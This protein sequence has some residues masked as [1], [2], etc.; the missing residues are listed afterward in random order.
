MSEAP[1]L[2]SSAA[3]T[4]YTLLRQFAEGITPDSLPIL[5]DGYLSETG[6][7]TDAWRAC[8]RVALWAETFQEILQTGELH[9]NLPA[10]DGLRVSELRT[11]QRGS[12]LFVENPD[13]EKTI[14]GSVFPYLPEVTL[15][16]REIFVWAHDVPLGA[17]TSYLGAY[18]G[19]VKSDAR[20][21]TAHIRPDPHPGVRV[22]VYGEPGETREVVLFNE[23]RGESIIVTFADVPQVYP[24]GP[25]QIVA[26]STEMAGRAWFPTDEN[27]P[28][29]LGPEMVREHTAESALIE[30]APEGTPSLYALYPDG[31]LTPLT[32]PAPAPP[33]YATPDFDDSDWLELDEPTNMA[34][35]GDGSYRTGWYRA[36]VNT[37]EPFDAELHFTALSDRLTLWVNGEKVGSSDSL[38]ENRRQNGTASFDIR[39]VPG[40]N[41]FSVLVEP[42]DTA[43][44]SLPENRGLY[45]PV[46]LMPSGACFI[47]DITRWRFKGIAET[48]DS[49][50]LCV[51]VDFPRVAVH[52]A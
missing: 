2:S 45:A 24:I 22:Y 40:E 35:L 15:R 49:S 10:T 36:T 12:L 31:G 50:P 25:S 16:P 33:E 52:P 46:T 44:G 48:V 38:P 32:Q 30:I 9:R 29:L 26:L 42:P 51:R 19:L 34:H 3:E 37:D 47:V 20:V 21:L 14:S 5:C 17:S 1:S 43:N 4:E 27:A 13:T 23:G 18:A 11:K 41:L 39:L 6:R 7:P 8:R 28:V